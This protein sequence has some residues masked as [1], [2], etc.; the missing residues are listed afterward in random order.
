MNWSMYILATDK[1]T[2]KIL[3][4]QVDGWWKLYRHSYLSIIIIS[5]N[6]IR[7]HQHYH[8]YHQLTILLN[9]AP[10]SNQQIQKEILV[11]VGVVLYWSRKADT[12]KHKRRKSLRSLCC[13]ATRKIQNKW[14]DLDQPDWPRFLC[15]SD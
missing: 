11:L 10:P 2:N 4:M 9:Q 12:K 15:T 6:I 13:F 8:H 14:R 1:Q 5:I 3:S 7:K